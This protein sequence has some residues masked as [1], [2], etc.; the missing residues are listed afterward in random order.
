MNLTKIAEHMQW[1]T[2]HLAED[3]KV[4]SVYASD[5]LS[6]VI[7]SAQENS[8]WITIQ[9]H[10]NVLAVAQLKKI[11]AIVFIKGEDPEE[12]F[13]QKAKEEKISLFKTEEDTFQTCGKLYQLLKIEEEQ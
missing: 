4:N 7:A 12:R 6:D 11:A 3:L 9:R 5:L 8:I 2:I 1:K 13:I 10:F